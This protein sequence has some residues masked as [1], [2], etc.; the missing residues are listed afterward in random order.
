MHRLTIIIA[1]LTLVSSASRAGITGT[2]VDAATGRPVRDYSFIRRDGQ[3]PRESIWQQHTVKH[4]RAGPFAIAD[5][6]LWQATQIRFWADGY[7]PVVVDVKRGRDADLAIKL[8][9]DS[10]LH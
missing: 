4:V 3:R 9:R 2:V 6:R 7:R 5:Q 1:A 10:G 8:E